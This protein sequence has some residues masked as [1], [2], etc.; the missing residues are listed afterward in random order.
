MIGAE[1]YGKYFGEMDLDAVVGSIH[2]GVS[3]RSLAEIPHVRYRE[4]R[5]MPYFFPD[6]LASEE[7]ANNLLNKYWLQAR[8]PMMRK[9]VDRIGFGG[10]LQLAAK[11][12]KFMDS[13]THICQEYACFF[14]LCW[15]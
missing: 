9:P 14:R 15:D 8:R 11:L 2:S 13:I 12:P 4:G 1:F 5:F 3:A 6:H 10:Y 7:V